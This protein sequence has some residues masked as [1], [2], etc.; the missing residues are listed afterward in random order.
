MSFAIYLTY[1][2]VLSIVKSTLVAQCNQPAV[3]K[4]EKHCG[5]INL[6]LFFAVSYFCWV[7]TYYLLFKYAYNLFMYADMSQLLWQSFISLLGFIK[8]RHLLKE[9]MIYVPCPC[10]ISA[11]RRKSF[12]IF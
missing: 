5:R 2:V 7:F 6:F 9:T 12:K 4:V 3:F 11:G 10:E 8:P 1:S